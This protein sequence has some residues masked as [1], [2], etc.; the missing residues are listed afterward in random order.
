M[1]TKVFISRS[2]ASDSIFNSMSDVQFIDRYLIEYT[3]IPFDLQ[4]VKSCQWLFFYSKKSIDYFISQLDDTIEIQAFKTICIGQKTA[5]YFETQTGVPVQH[6]IQY[7]M[8]KPSD[9]IQDIV[10]KDPI[11]FVQGKHSFERFQSSLPTDQVMQCIVYDNTRFLDAP[12]PACSYYIFTSPRNTLAFF[13][14]QQLPADAI[15]LSIG[16]STT[17]ELKKHYSGKIHQSQSSS[18]ESLKQLLDSF[19]L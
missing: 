19:I 15:V 7:S 1:K 17:N 11:C 10:G 14:H 13:T 4:L 5:E 2:L 16:N 8:G 3:S 18:E 9:S 12:I 6:I